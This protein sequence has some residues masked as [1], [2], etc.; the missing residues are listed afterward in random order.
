MGTND[1]IPLNPSLCRRWQDDC[2]LVA[3]FFEG[4]GRV[5]F[6]VWVKLVGFFG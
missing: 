2:N 4:R 5:V 3:L 6:T 1:H